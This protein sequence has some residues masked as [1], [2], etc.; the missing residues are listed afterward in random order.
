MTRIACIGEAMIELSIFGDDAEVGVAGDTLNTAIY[1]RRCAPDLKVDYVTC[2]G[3]D[4]LSDRI[5][6]FIAAHGL[7]TEAIKIIPNGTPGLYAINTSP[8]G[9]R[10]FTYWRSASAARQLFSDEKFSVLSDYDALY[11]SGISLAI[12]PS[13]IRLSL[14]DWLKTYPGKVIY[15]SN[16]RPQLWEDQETARAV[17]ADLWRR[18]D[19]ALPSIDDEMHLFEETADQVAARFSGLQAVGA[20]KRGGQGPMSIGSRVDQHYTRSSD[21]VDTTAA[22][23]SFNGAYLAALLT[24]RPQAEALMAGHNMASKVIRY[25]GAIIPE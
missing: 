21:I 14:V 22:G 12:L 9:E 6:R 8:D 19:I 13:E 25:R 24:G 4:P 7:G 10:S 11:L 15:D 2:L 20:L 1:M 23:D 5:L 3:D 18:T 17:T 16:Y